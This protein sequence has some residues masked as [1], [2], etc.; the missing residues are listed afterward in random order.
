[1]YKEIHSLL[2]DTTGS[3]KKLDLDKK[4][5]SRKSTGRKEHTKIAS[6]TQLGGTKTKLGKDAKFYDFPV[7]QKPY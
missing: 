6:T 4:D 3:T 2:F 5:S 1:M 7:D